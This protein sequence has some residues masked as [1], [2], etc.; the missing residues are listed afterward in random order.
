VKPEG[1]QVAVRVRFAA[2]LAGAVVLGSCGG[3]GGNN[4][5]AHSAAGPGGDYLSPPSLTTSAITP[6]GRLALTGAAS[7]G[8][9]VRVATPAGQAVW[10]AADEQGVWKTELPT[11]TEP[12]LFGLSMAD[13]A[14]KRTVQAEGYLAI[15]PDGRAA[16]LRAGAG[17]VVLG[18]SG[19]GL[20]IL[21]VD[22]DRQGGAV[23][24]GLAAPGA[25]VTVRVDSV[26]RGQS[27]ADAEGRFDV[28]LSQPLARGDHQ[29]EA[30]DGEHQASTVAPVSPAPNLTTGPYRAERAA[31]GWR[32]DWLTPGGG[33][34][35]TIIVDRTEAAH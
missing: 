2:V 14:G 26:Q 24:A 17:A 6:A 3:R 27:A 8:L 16:Q 13:A 10:A 9:K 31:L 30:S 15:L 28:A 34:Q 12:R 35:S 5:D 25:T 19:G 23:I 1:I 20:K 7:P 11:A 21:A 4:V 32:I 29:I 22:Y 18:A 33:V